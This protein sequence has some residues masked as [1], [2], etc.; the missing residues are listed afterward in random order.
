MTRGCV[1]DPGMF[2]SGD[3]DK[4][5]RRGEPDSSLTTGM[6]VESDEECE[7][8]VRCETGRCFGRT[9]APIL[10]GLAGIIAL[11]VIRVLT[12]RLQDPFV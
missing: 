12:S 1:D 11:I 2:G 9:H 5:R 10:V 7:Q 3:I 4:L 6:L 8:H